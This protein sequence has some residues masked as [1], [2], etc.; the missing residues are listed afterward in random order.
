MNQV[1]IPKGT[2]VYLDSQLE[3][4]GF[5]D[6][7]PF[8]TRRY[9]AFAREL[10]RQ[11]IDKKVQTAKAPLASEADVLRFHSQD[12]LHFLKEKEKQGYGYFD[13]GDTPVFKGALVAA[14]R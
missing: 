14:R 13:Y 2:L 4:Y 1:S 6:G 10:E 3:N 8:S 5:P 12:Y 9:Q 11:G 7:H